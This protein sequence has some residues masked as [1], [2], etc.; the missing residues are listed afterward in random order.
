MHG[1]ERFSNYK[2]ARV[3]MWEETLL[4]MLGLVM[5]SFEKLLSLADPKVRLEY[6]KDDIDALSLKREM[7]WERANNAQFLT[8]NEKRGLMG[9]GPLPEGDVLAVA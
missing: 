8:I 4:P 5:S 6:S 7:L 2:E 3:H 9:F 1:D